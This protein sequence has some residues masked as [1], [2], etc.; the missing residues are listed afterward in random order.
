MKLKYKGK[1]GTT[2]IR[3]FSLPFLRCYVEKTKS[4]GAHSFLVSLLSFS[5]FQAGESS[6]LFSISL[7]S[8]S[9]SYFSST[10]ESKVNT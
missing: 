8:F 2:K 9:L 7:L 1:N 6:Y 3:H 10:K 4:S 5:A